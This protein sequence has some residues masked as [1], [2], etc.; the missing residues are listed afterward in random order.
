MCA[1]R[2]SAPLPLPLSIREEVEEMKELLVLPFRP[3]CNCC[4]LPLFE[5]LY[6]HACTHSAWTSGVSGN[7]FWTFGNGNG[8]GSA[9]FQCQYCELPWI[10]DMWITD[11]GNFYQRFSKI[12]AFDTSS[13]INHSD[14]YV[15]KSTLQLWNW[16]SFKI[17][18][19][20]RGDWGGEG[21][22]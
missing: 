9:H 15:S 20:G 14:E 13:L 1:L 16:L 2:I 6:W 17:F 21:E 10:T 3:L 12:H 22:I 5:V 4:Q 11:I 8:N 19:V 18:Q 7:D